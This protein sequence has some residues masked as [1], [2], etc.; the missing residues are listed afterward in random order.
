[1]RIKGGKNEQHKEQCKKNRRLLTKLERRNRA[2]E[3]VQ[4]SMS[5]TQRQYASEVLYMDYMS[6]EDSDYEEIEDPITEERERKLACY[7][8]KKLPWEKTSLTSLKSRLDRAYHNSLSSHARAMSKPR[9]VG[10]LSTRPAP[11]GPSWA[12]RQPD[13]ETA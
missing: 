9:K 8:T 11:E 2:F 10:G 4:S 12:V 1:M 5:A 7:I 13:D 6:S 3:L